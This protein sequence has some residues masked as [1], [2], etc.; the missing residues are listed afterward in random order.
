MLV[1]RT[2]LGLEADV[3]GRT[4]TVS[5]TVPSRFRSLEV[6]GLALAGQPLHV[7]VDDHGHVHATTTGDIRVTSAP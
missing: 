3:P 2:V 6:T 1:L 7:S 4:L 5:G